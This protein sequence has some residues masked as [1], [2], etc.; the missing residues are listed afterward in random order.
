[1]STPTRIFGKTQNKFWHPDFNQ[2][3]IFWN[4]YLKPKKQLLYSIEW[5]NNQ[6]FVYFIQFSVEIDS[7][8]HE[9]R[10]FIKKIGNYMLKNSARV[11]LKI[12]EV[13]SVVWIKQGNYRKFRIYSIKKV[14]KTRSLLLKF[15]FLYAISKCNI[16][17]FCTFKGFLGTE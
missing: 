5:A 7:F 17:I 6:L 4:N 9:L 3:Y 13:C 2:I 12:Y 16:L 14:N 15:D 10:K 1:M 11:K 8:P